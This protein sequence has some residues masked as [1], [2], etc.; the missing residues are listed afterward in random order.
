MESLAWK[1][2]QGGDWFPPRH[3]AF[4][5]EKTPVESPGGLVGEAAVDGLTTWGLKPRPQG[6]W[7]LGGGR[8]A[9]VGDHTW[10][11]PARDLCR[12]LGQEG[13]GCAR[14]PPT[15]PCRGASLPPGRP[16]GREALGAEGGSLGCPLAPALP[17]C[18]SPCS[19]ALLRH[20][21]G[22]AERRLTCAYPHG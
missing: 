17:P 22:R 11:T 3:I 19:P 8:V 10:F 9:C 15:C 13:R 5:E 2:G 1:F 18:V 14:A 21:Q 20:R 4:Q 12:G 6:W 16:G 7:S